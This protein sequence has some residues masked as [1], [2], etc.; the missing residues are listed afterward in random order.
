MLPE[1]EEPPPE[2]VPWRDAPTALHMLAQRAVAARLGRSVA[3]LTPA[4]IE[5]ARRW[6]RV[7]RFGVVEVVDWG[8]GPEAPGRVARQQGR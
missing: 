2:G 5:Q 1:E 4:D 3:D 8:G 6:W 7:G